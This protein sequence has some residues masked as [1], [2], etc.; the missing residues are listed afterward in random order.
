MN[1]LRTRPYMGTL[2]PLSGLFDNFLGNLGH[3]NWLN[4]MPDGL[5]RV[6]ISEKDEV[7]QLELL[8]PG[9]RKGDLKLNVEKDMLTISAEREREEDAGDDHDT[10]RE[11]SQRSSPRSCRLPEQVDADGI[12]AEHLRGVL[13]VSMP[14]KK[15]VEPA[16][17]QISIA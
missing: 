15:D 12:K 8:A 13:P 7:F 14:K 17:K 10:R 5:P 16:V 2:T 9:V 1:Y 3:A 6:N 4:D 11:F